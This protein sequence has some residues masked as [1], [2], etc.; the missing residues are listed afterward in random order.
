ME[1]EQ[2]HFNIVITGDGG[3]GKSTFIKRHKDKQF[4]GEYFPTSIDE[5]TYLTFDTNDH[6]Y[7]KIH[8]C[9]RDTSGQTGLFNP[10]GTLQGCHAA[11]VFYDLGS[12]STA[13][14]A[15]IKRDTVVRHTD[16]NIPLIVCGNKEDGEVKVQRIPTFV[17]SHKIHH[18]KLSVQDL[19]T[20]DRKDKFFYP[21][22]YLLRK[23][24]EN[25]DLS[26]LNKW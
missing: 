12:H 8:L 10:I 25:E 17:R 23:L 14:K 13:M 6:R 21:F 2:A 22:E 19:S 7:P 5:D 20:P 15:R 16:G 3:V 1:E 9:V 26:I 11:M 4:V 18:C 24:T